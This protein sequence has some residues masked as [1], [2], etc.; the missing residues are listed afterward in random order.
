[1]ANTIRYRR[2]KGTASML[3]QLARDVTG[4]PARV[5]EFFELLTT[6]QHMKHVRAHAAGTADLRGADRL[7][8][9]APYQAGA[10]ESGTHTAEMR[11]IATA[12]GRYN[13]ANVGIFLWRIGAQPVVRSDLVP[14]RDGD[15]RRYRFDPLGADT[16]LFGDPRPEEDVGHLT[17][18]PA[19]P[20]D[21]PIPLSVRWARAN[22]G[23][24]YGPDGSFLLEAATAGGDP[25]PEADVDVCDLADDPAAPGTWNNEAPGAG[26]A[27]DGKIRIDP[28]LGRVLYPDDPEPDEV[29]LATWRRG[30]AL[31][32]GGGGYDRSA[33]ARRAAH[34]EAV[35][36]GSGL[37][38]ALAAVAAGGAAEIGDSR[39]YAAPA[40][41]AVEAPPDGADDRITRLRA[42]NRTRPLL[43]VTDEVRLDLV[44]DTVLSLDGLL[45][46]GGPLVI[47]EVDDAATR[48]LVIRHCTLV[49]GLTRTHDGGPGTLGAASLVVLH[50]HASVTIEKSVVGPIVA[51]AGA[52]VTVVDSIVDAC[53]RDQVAYGGRARPG[54]GGLRTVAAPADRQTGDGVDAGGDLI[55]ESSTVVGRVHATRLDVS[56]SIVV[57]LALEPAD[58]W[59]APLWAERRQVGCVRFSSIPPVAR[60][61]RPYRCVPRDDVPP[62]AVPQFTSLRFGDPA[63]GQ[64]RRSTHPAIRTGAE[65]EAEMGATRQLHQ[66]QR[67]SNLRVRLEEYLRFGLEAGC[68]F[69]T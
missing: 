67:E 66:P 64:L 24:Y 52:E 51:V 49:P 30:A 45:I 18:R 63:Y 5:V 54:G 59:P 34:V 53:G 55:L 35:S 60:V 65:D 21:L 42:A 44:A 22:L 10:F 19:Q 31:D 27:S 4:W 26:G 9:G 1:V 48:T 23:T 41:I 2:R 15:T 37:D 25:V 62:T 13:I 20:L 32:I 39:R 56:S 17:T 28:R 68:F 46:A 50:P 7:A 11:R 47:D 6:T 36:G 14:D 8:L 61:P 16:T 29:R 57:A 38:A 33:D 69:A 40:T 12:D 58:P 3:E 43:Q